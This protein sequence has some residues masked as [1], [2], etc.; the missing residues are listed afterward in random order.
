MKIK[1]IQIIRAFAILLIV[2]SHLS[3]NE[4]FL[5]ARSGDFP[6]TSAVKINTFAAVDLF[7][8]ISGFI[9]VYVSWNLAPS[10]TSARSFILARLF[11]IVPFWWMYCA[12]HILS[13]FVLTGG[14]IN[15]EAVPAD[16]TA[17]SYAV[18]SAFFIPQGAHPLVGQG[19]TLVHEFYFYVVFTGLILLPR[20]W[21]PFLL[22]GWAGLVFLGQLQGLGM[23]GYSARDYPNLLSSPM[24]YEFIAGAFVGWLYVKGWVR[25][26]LIAFFVGL[27][28]FVGVIAIMPRPDFTEVELNPFRVTTFIVPATLIVI[29]ATGMPK[30]WTESLPGR[31]FARLG[32]W[33]YSIFLGHIFVFRGVSIV[34]TKIASVLGPSSTLGKLFALG[35]PGVLDNILYVTTCVVGTIVIGAMSYEFIERPIIKF[36]NTRFRTRQPDKEKARLSEH[37]AP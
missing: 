8:V 30:A 35:S 24:T 17:L 1:G 33:S 12:I 34:F 26:A 37:F 7:F 31:A 23:E 28:W 27:I 15:P 19:W 5:I 16:G 2:F 36:L 25:F 18:K 14:W 9:M 32:T 6:I 29:G 3:S 20:R 11:R 10:V 22:I 4:A 21:L 13:T